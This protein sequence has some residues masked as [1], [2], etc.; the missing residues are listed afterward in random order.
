M[1]SFTPLRATLLDLACALSESNI[2][3]IV[4]G[5]FGLYLKQEQLRQSAE[6]TLL[7]QLPEPRAT[8]DIDLFLR[9][10]VLASL[11]SMQQIANSLTSLDFHPVENAKYFQW[12][13]SFV[14]GGVEQEVKLDLLVGP[15][16]KS[17]GNLKTD[18]P[19]RVRPKGELRL[20]AYHT[21]EALAIDQ[22]SMPIPVSGS[23][24]GG[25]NYQAEVFIPHAFTYLMM[26][27]HAFDDRKDDQSKDFGR[28]H[29]MDLYRIVAMM[30]EPEYQR[31]LE[32][33]RSYANDSRVVRARSI[34]AADYD[35]FTS[36][37]VLRLREHNLYRDNLQIAEFT[38][39]LREVFG[40]S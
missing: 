32:L 39:V 3:L 17:V 14:G 8:N 36:L 2:P 26:K 21:V 16:S 20:H 38:S 34:V 7:E 25:D 11:A 12:R 1:S 33:G 29:A 40:L 24:A 15:I 19:P 37:G 35:S 4:G 23:R 27:L 22:E 31:T 28:H 30:T 9:V 13:R 5:G 18:K 6:R 10:D